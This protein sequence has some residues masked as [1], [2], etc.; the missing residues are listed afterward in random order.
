MIVYSV[1]IC[2]H[3]YQISQIQASNYCQP[4]LSA[5][6]KC[7]SFHKL[8]DFCHS[9]LSANEKK[10]SNMMQ[11]FLSADEILYCYWPKDCLQNGD[12]FSRRGAD[13]FVGCSGQKL[14]K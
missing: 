3:L 8:A 2:L 11:N 5:C 6:K 9:V 12:K 13:D 4:T 10:L 14:S 1:M 7:S